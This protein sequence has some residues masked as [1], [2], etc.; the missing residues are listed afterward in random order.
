MQDFTLTQKIIEGC[1]LGDGHM[2]RGKHGKTPEF[3]YRTSSKQ[4]AEFVHSY[5]K[6]Y[7]SNNYQ[8]LKRYEIFDKRTNKTYVG[9]FF[10]TRHLEIFNTIYER[11]YINKIK[12]V[13]KDLSVDKNVLLFWYIGDGELESKYGYIKLHT[14]SFTKNEVDFLCEQLKE[15]NAKPLHKEKGQYLVTI[16]RNRVKLMLN[17]I[18]ECPFSDYSH[19]WKF[20]EYKNKNIEK[21]GIKYYSDIYPKIENDFNTGKYTICSLSKKY[22]VHVN[23][24]RNY[25]NKNKV[26]WEPIVTKKSIVQYDLNG[27]LIKEWISGQEIKQNL[28]FNASA[29]SECCRGIRKRYKGFI[30]KF[31]N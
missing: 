31:K 14:N 23:A 18:G 2:T 13:P 25:F 28:G 21:N 3:S 16:P 7:C 5:L 17:F 26:K 9:Y 11:F 24:I 27:N 6:E 19:K 4:H 10:R 15:Y 12:I 1:L 22:N 20:V 30:W 29:I 8:E